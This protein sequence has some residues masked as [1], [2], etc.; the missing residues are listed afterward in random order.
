MID[1]V[2]LQERLTVLNHWVGAQK[3]CQ[4]DTDN[5]LVS[6]R[7]DALDGLAYVQEGAAEH[8]FTNSRGVVTLPWLS[9][10]QCQYIIDT[11]E[12]VPFSVNEDE[13]YLAQMPEV[14]LQD[15]LPDL[16]DEL[17]DK[18]VAELYG[19]ILL[20][21]GISIERIGSIQVAKY[22]ADGIRQ[23]VW[24][25]D[26]DSDITVTVALNDDFE[27]GGVEIMS[28][29]GVLEPPYC[30]DSVVRGQAT[31]FRGR[32]SLHRGLPVTKGNRYILVFWCKVSDHYGG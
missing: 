16:H 27:G 9:P 8:L 22:S 12:T 2:K 3:G 19:Y 1:H 30:N 32:T 6:K 23:G 11:V 21:T 25:H 14:V 17:W 13:P 28:T 10:E 26:N 18:F 15:M 31:V 20:Q 29:N 24:H 7:D 4:E 5:F